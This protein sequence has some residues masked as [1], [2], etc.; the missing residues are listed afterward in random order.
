M[1]DEKEQSVEVIFGSASGAGAYLEESARSAAPVNF[2]PEPK[3]GPVG[4]AGASDVADSSG[5]E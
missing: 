2:A 4:G 3:V 1:D 5:A